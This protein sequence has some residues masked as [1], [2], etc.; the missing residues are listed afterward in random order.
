MNLIQLIKFN[1]WSRL[2]GNN[3]KESRIDHLYSNNSAAINDVNSITPIMGDH[4]IIM[5]TLGELKP[6]PKIT[7]RRNWKNYSKSLLIELLDQVEFNLEIPT[8]QEL[9]NDI[10]NKIIGVVDTIAPITKFI[11]TRLQES[12]THPDWLK[13]KI[14]L[15][16]KLLRK[17][18]QDKTPELKS[19]LK[20]LSLEIKYHF[21]NETKSKVRRGI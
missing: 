13:R 10:E 8:V 18:K 7:E 17:L 16:K 4:K 20:N 14:N 15:R 2:V 1:T 12:T 11:N 19:R 5:A 9:A 6:I 3:W 21:T